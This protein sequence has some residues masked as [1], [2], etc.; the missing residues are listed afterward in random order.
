MMADLFDYLLQTLIDHA[1]TERDKAHSNQS[2]TLDE[3]R[4]LAT[5]VTKLE[6]AQMWNERAKRERA[7]T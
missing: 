4:S 5:T 3:K 2:A 1:R 6:E 7:V